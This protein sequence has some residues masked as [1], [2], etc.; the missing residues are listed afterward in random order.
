MLGAAAAVAIL[1]A[2]GGGG[3]TK[4]S[5]LSAAWGAAGCTYKLYKDL[6]QQHV[7][8]T[9]AKVKY[10]SFP[11]T[12]G[13]H[14]QYAMPWNS[15]PTEV[16]QVQLVHNLEHGGIAI[17]YGSKVPQSEVDKLNAFVDDDPRGM[18]LAPLPR[19]GGTIAVTA[20]RRLAKCRRFDEKA[21][22]TFRDAR[23]A[24][25]PERFDLAMLGRGE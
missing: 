4:E 12:S 6:G 23:R 5:D 3:G 14:Y 21:Y 10:N 20:W 13:P 15:Y 1:V 19:L 17:Q 2:F 25:G 7:N 9:K 11:P 24:R 22:K 16:S 8:S 18:I